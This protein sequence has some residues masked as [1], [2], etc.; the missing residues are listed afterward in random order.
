MKKS[1]LFITIIIILLTACTTFEESKNEYIR[2]PD[3]RVIFTTGLT[4]DNL[5]LNSLEEININEEMIFIYIQW[6]RI[7]NTKYQ[8]VCKMFDGSGEKINE[9]AMD[10]RPN[11]DG[12][13]TWTWYKI[14]SN[15]DVPGTWRFEIYLDETKV[16][17][18]QLT[19]NVLE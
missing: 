4:E 8:Y 5:P 2:N 14:K 12:W 1:F 6:N 13:N 10:F 19:V 17:E 16:I 9:S 7:P 15:V 3:Y 11:T 18:S